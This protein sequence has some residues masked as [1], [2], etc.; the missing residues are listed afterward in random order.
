MTLAKHIT[1]LQ[2]LIRAA[3]KDLAPEQIQAMLVGAG[4]TF[5]EFVPIKY[6]Q[7]EENFEEAY[8]SA[9]NTTVSTIRSIYPKN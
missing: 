8:N 9:F 2:E 4:A 5:H 7:K 3:Q 1:S 6:F